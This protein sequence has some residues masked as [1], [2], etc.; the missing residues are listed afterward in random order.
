MLTAHHADDQIV[1]MMTMLD[2]HA[3]NQQIALGAYVMIQLQP[4]CRLAK[5]CSDYTL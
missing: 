5:A 3:D 1:M 4:S 2:D